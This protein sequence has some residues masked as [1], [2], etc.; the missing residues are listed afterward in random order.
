MKC[1]Y[2][3]LAMLCV[4]GWISAAQVGKISFIVG[5]AYYRVNINQPYKP[6]S[7]N[8]PISDTGYLKTGLDSSV[9]VL[10]SN[11]TSST[12]TANRQI[13]LKS[14]MAEANSKQSLRKKLENKMGNLRLQSNRLISSEAGIRRSE[15]E[16][17]D[18]SL[19]YWHAEPLQSIAECIEL[20]DSKQYARAIPLFNKVIEQS[21]LM[22]DAELA[23]AYLMII[24]EE[25]GNTAM[26]QKH[27]D[28]LKQ[29]FP[30]S[31]LIE[32]LPKD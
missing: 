30:G 18:K 23:H 26:L 2:V 4:V 6:V 29:D 16:V 27:I 12:L 32:S 13:S 9:E 19:L 3:T 25:M 20:F 7:M 5:E 22:K 24:Y 8:M 21:P 31:T 28:I 10:W 1:T 11:G 15:A 14:L 17:Q